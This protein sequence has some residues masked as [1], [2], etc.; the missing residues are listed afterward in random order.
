M[1][2]LHL[3]GLSILIVFLAGQ[4]AHSAARSWDLDK[5]HSNIY[6]SI[7]HI[8]SKVRGHFDDFKLE[9]N[10]EPQNLQESRFA[11][12]IKVDSIDTNIGKR[13][14]HLKSADFFDAG[15]YPLISFAS[16]K[17]TDAGNGVYEVAGK[18]TIKDQTYDLTL[19]LSLA[20]VKDHPSQKGKEVAGFNGEITIDRLAYKVGNGK[21]FDG[22]I[23]GKD[24]DVLVTLEVLSDK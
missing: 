18:L 3:V 20:G 13:D 19:P 17:I 16:E 7:E 8:F 12:E 2:K 22:G 23:I 1:K 9:V 21:F 11:F 6:F 14:K 24:V 5:A 10:F 4:S 15:K